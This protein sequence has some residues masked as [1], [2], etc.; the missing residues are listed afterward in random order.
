VRSLV[1]LVF[2]DTNV[3]F[4]PSLRTYRELLNSA[5][6]QG[7]RSDSLRTLLADFDVRLGA[8]GGVENSAREGWSRDVTGHLLTRLDLATHLPHQLLGMDSVIET[9]PSTV[10]YR[11]LPADRVF[12]NVMVGRL[13]VTAVRLSMYRELQASVGEILRILGLELGH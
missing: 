9:L 8:L 4:A 13:A 2:R 12:R 10:D 6:L 1:S 3:G 5:S 11:S 7:L